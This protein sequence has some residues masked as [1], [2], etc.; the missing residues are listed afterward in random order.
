LGL[1]FLKEHQGH[2]EHLQQYWKQSKSATW[3]IERKT[4]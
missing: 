4:S 3:G 1:C 2:H